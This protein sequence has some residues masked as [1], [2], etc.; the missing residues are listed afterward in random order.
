MD[1]FLQLIMNWGNVLYCKI[2]GLFFR[3]L[4]TFCGSAFTFN[5]KLSFV[6]IKWLSSIQFFTQI[7]SCYKTFGIRSP[8]LSPG[9]ADTMLGRNGLRLIKQFAPPVLGFILGYIWCSFQT[10]P[11]Q[12][13]TGV[14]NVSGILSKNFP[15]MY[16]FCCRICPYSQDHLCLC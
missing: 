9:E 3:D 12:E 1:K 4:V 5:I 10:P 13:E 7:K 2:W 14:E 11:Q 8:W 6:W 15:F 16:N